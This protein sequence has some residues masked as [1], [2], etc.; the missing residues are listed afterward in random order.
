M[1]KARVSDENVLKRENTPAQLIPP[2]SIYLTLC[3]SNYFSS[4]VE[5]PIYP[6]SH[7]YREGNKL[8]QKCC[9]LGFYI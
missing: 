6:I 9:R 7:L 4:G 3:L 1:R 2:K 5:N 8:I